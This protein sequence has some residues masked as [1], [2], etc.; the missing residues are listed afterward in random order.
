MGASSSEAW[1]HS[2]LTVGGEKVCERC[3]WN[4]GPYVEEGEVPLHRPQHCVYANRHPLLMHTAT[5]TSSPQQHP[6]MPGS[7]NKQPVARHIPYR[8]PPPPPPLTCEHHLVHHTLFPR[9]R[10]RVLPRHGAGP[11]EGVGRVGGG[12]R[13]ARVG[14]ALR[15]VGTSHNLH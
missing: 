4:R 15:R 14:G 3:T 9:H 7:T 11:V 6:R 10:G 12:Q 13:V 1:Y 8:P 2:L 5:E